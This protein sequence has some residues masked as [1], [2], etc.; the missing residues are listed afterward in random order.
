MVVAFARSRKRSRKI[1]SGALMRSFP[2]QITAMLAPYL[3]GFLRQ[4]SSF[5]QSAWCCLGD[6]TVSDFPPKSGAWRGL[7]HL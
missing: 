7:R 1:S 4:Q 6:T 3:L 2:A 5:G